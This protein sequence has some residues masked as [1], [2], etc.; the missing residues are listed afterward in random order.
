VAEATTIGVGNAAGVSA[1]AAVKV[2]D[3]T[4]GGEV[5]MGSM[6][7]PVDSGNKVGAA[8]QAAKIHIVAR[9]TNTTRI[10]SLF[11]YPYYRASARSV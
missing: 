8:V 10:V 6:G 2:G 9:S 7:V 5:V 4:G 1:S 11:T 3:G